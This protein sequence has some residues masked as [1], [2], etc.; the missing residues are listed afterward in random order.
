[1]DGTEIVEVAGLGEA[2][3]I[4][5]SGHQSIRAYA[6]LDFDVV[7][8]AVCV[9]PDDGISRGDLLEGRDESE[10]ADR[11]AAAR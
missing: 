5:R 4:A 10:I 6:A 1:M 2:R 11:N 9:D 8:S 3:A 7:R